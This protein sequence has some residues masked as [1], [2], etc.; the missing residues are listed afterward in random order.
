[1]T[2]LSRPHARGKRSGDD[3]ASP[4]PRYQHRRFRSAQAGGIATQRPGPCDHK[5][6]SPLRFDC[7]PRR[8]RRCLVPP[9]ASDPPGTP[10]AAT[11][12]HEKTLSVCRTQE[13][14][15]DH[16]R[17]RRRYISGMRRCHSRGLPGHRE[18]PSVSKVLEGNQSYY[19]PGIHQHCDP[20]SDRV[21]RRSRPPG[22]GLLIDCA[23]FACVAMR[24]RLDFWHPKGF[25]PGRRN[26]GRGKREVCSRPAQGGAGPAPPCREQGTL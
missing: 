9:G 22:W 19:F 1:M 18:D 21:G 10:A 25:G 12:A 24:R 26:S 6:G 2:A 13:T 3:S 16:E 23:F 5:T 8:I 20:A 7:Y 17:S 11:T 4:R 15:A 14:P